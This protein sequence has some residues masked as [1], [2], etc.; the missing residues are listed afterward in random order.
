MKKYQCECCGG[1]VNPATLKCEYCGMAYRVDETFSQPILY[2]IETYTN[3]VNTFRACASID[4]HD[5]KRFGP[6]YCSKHAIDILSSKLSE[7]LSQNMVIDSEVDL[8]S[9]MYRV[10]GTVKVVRPVNGSEHWALNR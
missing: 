1:V 10:Q 9:G 7:V 4:P 6:E 5:V 2:K 8:N 3:P